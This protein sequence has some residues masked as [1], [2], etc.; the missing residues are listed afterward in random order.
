M[1]YKRSQ[2]S[3]LQKRLKESPKLIIIVA[4][5]RQVGKSTLVRQVLDL[6]PSKTYI[7]ADSGAEDEFG[8]NFFSEEF[9]GSISRILPGS[10]KDKEW[11]IQ[12][13]KQ[14]RA[15]VKIQSESGHEYHVLAID[16]IQKISNW[17]EVIKGLWDD[18]RYT[19]TP[20]HVILLGS[21]QLLVQK[22]LVESLA[23]RYE[24]ITMTHWSYEEM[25]E[26]FDFSLNE[27]IYFGGYPGSVDFI[28]DENRWRNYVHHSLI[29]PIINKDILQMT[30]VDKPALLK[31]LFEVGCGGYSGQIISYTKLQG[32]LQD[33]GNTTTLAHYLNLLSEAC[34]LTGLPKYANK[35][36]R[37][38]AS[39][40][41]LN[42]HNTALISALGSYS[43]SAACNDRGY[44]GHLVESAVGSHLI[45]NKPDNCNLYYWRETIKKKSLEVD[46]ILTYGDKLVA[47]EVKSGMR[48]KVYG[49]DEFK[50]KYKSAKNLI[51]G[52]GGIPLQDFLIRP[53]K[54]YFESDI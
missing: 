26:A 23:G 39:S 4:G 42:V 54:T 33:A 2:I 38:R 8:V 15:K 18:D 16:E 46:F 27:Y 51:V 10:P 3:I 53:V 1:K 45:N 12:Q 7:N 13:W 44:W 20:L 35:K 9:D 28:K 49:L 43:F 22:G 52:D 50:K 30:R 29:G 17:S 48:G 31:N 36:H 32:Q 21:S 25:Q 47:I 34:L 11:L 40:P 24:L 37:Q 41:K 5:P 14:A 19:G 6:H